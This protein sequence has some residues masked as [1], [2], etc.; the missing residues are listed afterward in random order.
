M[1]TSLPRRA[2]A[3][4]ERQACGPQ[5]ASA[6]R[7]RAEVAGSAER[8]RPAGY[9]VPPDENTTSATRSP[10]NETSSAFL[11]T[12]YPLNAVPLVV[13]YR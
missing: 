5:A 7:V 10:S 12:L 6:A 1:A 2:L 11:D 3:C 4:E 9:L 8:L 13:E